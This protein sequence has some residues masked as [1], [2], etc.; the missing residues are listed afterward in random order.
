MSALILICNLS[1]INQL[2]QNETHYKCTLIGIMVNNYILNRYLVTCNCYWKYMQI[3]RNKTMYI[4]RPYH[5]LIGIENFH[6]P[7]KVTL[8]IILRIYRYASHKPTTENQKDPIS[9]PLSSYYSYI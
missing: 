4:Y 2:N 9:Q 3:K 1:I 8:H 6:I 7:N 5:I